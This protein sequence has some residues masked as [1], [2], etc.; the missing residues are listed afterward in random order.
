MNK[1]RLAL[2]NFYFSFDKKNTE[3]SEEYF[4]NNNIDINLINGKKAKLLKKVEAQQ[5]LLQGEKFVNK[6]KTIY[7]KIRNS[8]VTFAELGL[9]RESQE[10]LVLQYNKFRGNTEELFEDKLKEQTRLEIIE[11]IKNGEL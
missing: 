6:L 5:K 10:D 3:E 1:Q 8:E 7:E 2:L 4:R 11:K 9:S